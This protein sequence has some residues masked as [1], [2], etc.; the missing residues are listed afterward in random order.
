MKI[1]VKEILRATRSL[2]SPIVSVLISRWNPSSLLN[3][4]P[5]SH[6]IANKLELVVGTEALVLKSQ[7][8]FFV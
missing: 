3:S 2:F 5:V 6:R 1:F 4:F 7:G 8:F